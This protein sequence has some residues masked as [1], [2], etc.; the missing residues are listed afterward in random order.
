[1]LTTPF[2]EILGHFPGA[3]CF[4]RLNQCWSFDYQQQVSQH[5]HVGG[6]TDQRVPQSKYHEIF[7]RIESIKVEAEFFGVAR[8]RRPRAAAGTNKISRLMLWSSSR[9]ASSLVA[10]LKPLQAHRLYAFDH[11]FAM[12]ILIR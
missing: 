8:M 2:D 3:S 12:S 9:R 11:A 10:R 4:Q 1:M 5:H 6:W 7:E